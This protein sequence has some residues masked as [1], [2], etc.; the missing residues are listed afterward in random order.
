MPSCAASVGSA[1]FAYRQDPKM[2][3]LRPADRGPRVRIRLGG[4]GLICGGQTCSP[5]TSTRYGVS[6]SR[7]RPVTGTSA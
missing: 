5:S 2:I 6:L 7:S 3:R 1:T 4:N